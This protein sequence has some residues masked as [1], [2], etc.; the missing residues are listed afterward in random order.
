MSAVEH[1]QAEKTG[2]TDDHVA[3]DFG[4]EVLCSV[5]VLQGPESFDGGK[6]ESGLKETEDKGQRDAQFGD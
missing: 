3:P 5:A 4:V 6:F 2:N 1:V